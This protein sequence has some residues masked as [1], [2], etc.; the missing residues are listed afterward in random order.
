MVAVVD[1]E[2]AASA[3]AA[4]VLGIGRE[5]QINAVFGGSAPDRSRTLTLDWAPN[6]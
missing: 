3:A 2:T 5:A 6:E 1:G 4:L